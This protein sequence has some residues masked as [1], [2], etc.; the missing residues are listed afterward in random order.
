MTKENKEDFKN[1]TK[2]WICNDDYIDNDINVRDI[3]LITEKYRGSLHRD[4]NVNLKLNHKIAVIF[5]NIK[6]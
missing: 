6:K 2:C 5:H 4:Y 1:S 3:C